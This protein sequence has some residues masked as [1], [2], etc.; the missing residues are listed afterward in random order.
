[1]RFEPDENNKRKRN[2][3][4]KSQEFIS[5]DIEVRS[6]PRNEGIIRNGHVEAQVVVTALVHNGNSALPYVVRFANRKE[7]ELASQLQIGQRLRVT[8]GRFDYRLGRK[9]AEFLVLESALRSEY[10]ALITLHSNVRERHEA[11][12]LQSVARSNSTK[13]L[14]RSVLDA[15]QGACCLTGC[16]D[17]ESLEV[18][19]IAPPDGNPEKLQIQNCLLLRSDV[20]KL[21]DQNLIGIHPVSKKVRVAP[22][23]STSDYWELTGKTMRLPHSAPDSPNP[24]VLKAK[25]RKFSKTAAKVRKQLE[26]QNL[27]NS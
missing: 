27:Q 22:G 24:E 19:F 5:V 25:W 2:K 6:K 14:R 26:S 1:M 12:S 23:V 13:S 17:T 20:H 11:G 4:R 15:Y 16:S 21:L 8:R 7:L 10:E 18:A 3:P 9:G